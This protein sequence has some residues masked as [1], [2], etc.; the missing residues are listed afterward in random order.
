MRTKNLLTVALMCTLAAGV[1]AQTVDKNFHYGKLQSKGVLT[2]QKED[3]W[4]KHKIK[5]RSLVG[6]QTGKSDEIVWGRIDR[7]TDDRIIVSQVAPQQSVKGKFELLEEPKTFKIN[8]I[9]TFY[10]A[11]NHQKRKRVSGG[12]LFGWGTSLA[13]QMPLYAAM[14]PTRFD[15]D[16][17]FSSGAWTG[18][19]FALGMAGLGGLKLRNTM[20]YKPYSVN[21]DD[22]GWNLGS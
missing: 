11:S 10:H 18:Q 6:L 15:W 17:Y 16:Y 9:T 1:S 12:I 13:V 5:E 19:I 20:K 21:G 22:K 2:L 7:I 14:N 3:S 4:K 8:D